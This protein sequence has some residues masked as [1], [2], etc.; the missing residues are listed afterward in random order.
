MGAC[1]FGRP[2]PTGPAGG[3]QN[4]STFRPRDGQVAQPAVEGER[5]G[6]HLPVEEDQRNTEEPAA[7]SSARTAP[8]VA[9]S[10]LN[11]Q[12]TTPLR[13]AGVAEGRPDGFEGLRVPQPGRASRSP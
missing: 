5:P 8:S 12:L 1:C 3:S 2:E 13:V 11:D 6:D 7:L 9:P 4:A 10:G